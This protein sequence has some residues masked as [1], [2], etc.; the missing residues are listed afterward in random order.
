MFPTIAVLNPQVA[1][2]DTREGI[3]VLSGLE[4]RTILGRAQFSGAN[5][6]KCLPYGGFWCGMAQ[7]PGQ[8]DDACEEAGSCVGPGDACGFGTVYGPSKDDICVNGKPTDW[9]QLAVGWCQEI[10]RHICVTYWIPDTYFCLCEPDPDPN[11]QNEQIGNRNYCL[12]SA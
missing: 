4:M 6:R 10:R 12:P 2:G 11:V 1:D 3:T 8:G 7:A 9:C 5:A